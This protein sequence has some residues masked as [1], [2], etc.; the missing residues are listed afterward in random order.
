ME[1]VANN[2]VNQN[3]LFQENTRMN[4]RILFTTPPMERIIEPIYDRPKF[5]RPALAH[6]AG[7][8]RE[9]G[10]FKIKCI[11]AKFEQKNT[12]KLI[13]EISA[14]KPDIVAISAYTYEMEDVSILVKK[15]R[16]TSPYIL[17]VLGGSH[18]TAISKQTME[19]IPE[20][21]VGVIGE[22][23]NVIVEICKTLSDKAS[24][25]NI[26]GIVFRNKE[27]EIVI[28]KKDGNVDLDSATLPAWDLLPRAE[29][30]FVQTQRGC[31]FNC[32]FC[33]NP[34]GNIIR[35][36]SADSVIKE[37]SFLIKN[38]KPERISFGD[39][40]FAANKKFVHELLDKMIALSVGDKVSWDIQTHV[41][42][43]DDRLLSK[44]KRAKVKKVDVGVESGDKEILEKM[45]KMITKEDVVKVFTLFKKYKI[46]SGAFF[47]IGHPNE[48]KK[49][50]WETIKF[51]AE[52]NP[53]E[54]IFAIAV[55]FPGTKIAEYALR[56]E[57]GYKNLS[58]KWSTYRKQI[59]SAVEL[60]GISKKK[61]KLYLVV[62][63][64]YVFI[65]NLRF[66]DLIKFAF[67]YRK[68]VLSFLKNINSSY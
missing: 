48:T 17:I 54:P 33:L 52:I 4:L 27:K 61:L 30:Y 49:T 55:P 23:E 40:S 20:I 38:F 1:K 67:N 24:F 59:N 64:I 37:I 5:V 15:I 28:N 29:E 14:F 34:G 6:L 68:S 57:M 47:I 13:S 36:R 22:G 25:T 63:N 65:Y 43:I 19:E 62:G 12:E 56:G 42:F 10:N 45:G 26:S 66:F 18:I 31:P 41:K 3:K 46:K 58:L 32:N 9:Y 60:G 51:A 8:L 11:D 35:M 21:D 39:E 53:T 2:M 16:E 44:M 7:F 50:I